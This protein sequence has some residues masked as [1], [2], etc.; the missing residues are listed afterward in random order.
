MAT[1]NHYP[2]NESKISWTPDSGSE[3]EIFCD[4]VSPKV[5]AILEET[6]KIGKS[7]NFDKANMD[8][9][10]DLKIK[11]HRSQLPAALGFSLG[12]LGTIKVYP[13]RANAAVYDTYP[14]ILESFSRGIKAKQH[15]MY[16]VSFKARGDDADFASNY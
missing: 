14:V 5:M 7:T 16:D 9:T 6:T 12:A 13:D 1:R 3:T 10:F 4:D 11:L 15:M 8:W 2:A